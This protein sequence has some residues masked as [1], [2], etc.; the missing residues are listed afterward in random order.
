MNNRV[1][2]YSLLVA[3]LI[4]V[5]SVA[6]YFYQKQRIKDLNERVDTMEEALKKI[7]DL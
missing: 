6:F 3:G 7:Q 1:V 5:S 4:A 2:K